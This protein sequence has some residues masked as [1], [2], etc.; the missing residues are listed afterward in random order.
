MSIQITDSLSRKRD[1]KPAFL[2]RSDW[3]RRAIEME[4]LVGSVI[5]TQGMVCF[6]YNRYKLLVIHLFL[7]HANSLDMFSEFVVDTNVPD[8][9]HGGITKILVRPLRAVEFF[10]LFM[11]RIYDEEVNAS[12]ELYIATINFKS[13]TNIWRKIGNDMGATSSHFRLKP[14]TEGNGYTPGGFGIWQMA[15]MGKVPFKCYAIPD[16]RKRRK[17]ES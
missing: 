7:L 10:A 4:S 3:K 8:H 15:F 14:D 12:V 16:E 5:F 2:A 9:A 6:E 17:V 13:K 1:N 11:K